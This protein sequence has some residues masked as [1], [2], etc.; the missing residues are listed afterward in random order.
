MCRRAKRRAEAP[1]LRS[2]P[3]YLDRWLSPEEQPL[4]TTPPGRG[5]LLCVVGVGNSALIPSAYVDRVG[6]SVEARVGDP[7]A[8]GR[9]GRASSSVLLLVTW[10]LPPTGVYRV[11]LRVFCAEACVDDLLAVREVRRPLFAGTL[12]VGRALVRKGGRYTLG[13]T[14]TRRGRC[15]GN[16][17]L[18]TMAGLKAHRK[19]YLEKWVERAGMYDDEDLIFSS[20]IATPLNPENL[21]KRSFK[22]LF[23]RS[24]GGPVPRSTAHVRHAANGA[25]RSSQAR[26]GASWSCHHSNDPGYLL[27]L[28][29]LNGESGVRGYG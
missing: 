14:K 11:D 21:V 5:E 17:T 16:L 22:P 2:S 25:R 9:V 24:S 4:R 13:E 8:I 3:R 7:L 15:Q 28:S 27:A 23:K 10:N 20:E 29:P 12:H 18:R 26:A 19:R 1:K 6:V